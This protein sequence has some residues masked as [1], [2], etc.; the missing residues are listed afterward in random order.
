[1]L[2][3]SSRNLFYTQCSSVKVLPR[4]NHSLKI[5]C[6]EISRESRQEGLEKL[7][8]FCGPKDVSSLVDDPPARREFK[9]T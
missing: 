3:I 7:E 5:I 8:I 6:Y 2:E 4:A 9:D 1:M